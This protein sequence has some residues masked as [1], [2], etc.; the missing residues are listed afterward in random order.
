MFRMWGKI[1]KE[2]RLVRDITIVD[3]AP[4]SEKNRTKKVF[5]S[6]EEICY[7]FDIGKPIWLNVN[8]NEFKKIDKT[9]FSKD[10]FIEEIDFD[11]LEI[12]VIEEDEFWE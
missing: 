11:Y 7:A 8:I 5:D 6:L 1:W 3:Q 10:S 9:R 12:Q 2:N 4:A